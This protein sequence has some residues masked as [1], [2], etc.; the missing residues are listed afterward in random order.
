[1]LSDFTAYKFL[2]MKKI[3]LIFAVVT[4]TVSQFSCRKKGNPYA[5]MPTSILKDTTTVDFSEK[6]FLF[7]TIN[8]GDTVVHTFVIKNTGNK[9][10]IIAN[11]FGSCGCTVP[12]YPKEPL[13]PGKE[14][15]IVV[16]FNSA[17]KEGDQSKSVTL[18]LNTERHEEVLFLRG[19]V[20]SNQ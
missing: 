5:G 11:A 9:D 4:I 16:R 17:G 20:K 13:A 1:M 14:A 2:L 10:L 3:L 12:E 15:D 8:Q 7:D 6:E 18:Q 19:Y